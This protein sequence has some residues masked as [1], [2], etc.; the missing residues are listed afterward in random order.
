MW[1]RHQ[2]QVITR[3]QRP[4]ALSADPVATAKAQGATR[5]RQE[6]STLYPKPMAAVKPARTLAIGG[7]NLFP[8]QASPHQ[9]R[10]LRIGAIREAVGPRHGDV[11]LESH[12]RLGTVSNDTG[13]AM[14]EQRAGSLSGLSACG[15]KQRPGWARTAP[16]PAR[17]QSGAVP[18]IPNRSSAHHPTTRPPPKRPQG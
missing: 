4:W 2:L 6:A 8:G 3:V 15:S 1:R 18:Q 13:Q 14:P 17:R 11:W 7:A 16:V 9:A 5:Q 12:P 10:R